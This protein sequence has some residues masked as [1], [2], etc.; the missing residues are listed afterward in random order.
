MT[1][2]LTPYIL[3]TAAAP[4]GASWWDT[5]VRGGTVGFIILVLSVVALVL[6]IIHFVQIRRVWG[7][8]DP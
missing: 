2:L 5:I 6:V 8:N 3:A 4:E 1:S 7:I